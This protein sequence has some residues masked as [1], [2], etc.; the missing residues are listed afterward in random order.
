MC[1]EK[2]WS[3]MI[4][5]PVRVSSCTW[6]QAIAKKRLSSDNLEQYGR[7]RVS[8]KSSAQAQVLQHIQTV[9]ETFLRIDDRRSYN[10]PLFRSRLV[11]CQRNSYCPLPSSLGSPC[12]VTT[13]LHCPKALPQRF[14]TRSIVCD[15][16]RNCPPLT[17]LQDGR[18]A[19]RV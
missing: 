18:H 14:P 4:C 6:K 15:S 10:Q 2:T 11:C 8:R 19:S 17:A 5:H 16:R 1:N 13:L 3:N 9:V 12:L 7:A